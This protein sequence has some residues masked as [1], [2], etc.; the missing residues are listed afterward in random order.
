MKSNPKWHRDEIILALDL[1]FSPDRGS[2]DSKNPKI[3]AL[4]DLLRSLPLDLERPDPIKFR[5][6]NGVARKLANFMSLDKKNYA[7]KGLKGASK[8]DKILFEEFID[9]KVQLRKLAAEITKAV[10]DPLIKKEIFQIEEDEQTVQDSVEEGSILYKLHKVRERVPAI[11]KLKKE[12]TLKKKGKLLC[13]VC[14]FDFY[15]SYG[16]I[17]KGFIECHHRT[18][19]SSITA[20]TKTSLNDLALVCSNCHRML[21][22]DINTLSVEGLRERMMRR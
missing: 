10:T 1:Y 8:L 13:E 3:I 2:V 12:D 17:G 21:H 16:D 11:V 9:K 4:S 7:G 22:K 15:I 19:L 20:S 6:V 5:N 14:G 18:P